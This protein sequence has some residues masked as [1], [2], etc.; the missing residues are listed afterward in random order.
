M[1]QPP[2]RPS[3]RRTACPPSSTSRQAFPA[4]LYSLGDLLQPLQKLNG[5]GLCLLDHSRRACVI[6]VA[7]GATPEV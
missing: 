7:G 3:L 1:S 2:A 5:Q 4:S 6:V